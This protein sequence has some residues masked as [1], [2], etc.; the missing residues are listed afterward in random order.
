MSSLLVQSSDHALLGFWGELALGRSVEFLVKTRSGLMKK[1]QVFLISLAPDTDD[2]V[3]P[4]PA[5][6][7]ERG[8]LIEG[9]RGEA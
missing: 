3:Q 7:L 1:L 8:R 6:G 4:H 2:V 5:S 9:T